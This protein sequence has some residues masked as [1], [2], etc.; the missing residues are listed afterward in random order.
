MSMHILRLAFAMVLCLFGCG[1]GDIELV[2]DIDAGPRDGVRHGYR[3]WMDDL[4]TSGSEKE[5]TLVTYNVANLGHG[6]DQ[7]DNVVK[8]IQGSGADLVGLNE[9]D[10]CNGRHD[11]NQ[12]KNLAGKL[13][14]WDFYFAKA[15]D[16]AGGSYGNGV[17]S[18]KPILNTT[19]VAIPQGSGHEPRSIALI[20]TEDVVFGAV[21]L[22]FGPPGEPSYEQA[23]F[24]NSWFSE[25]YMGYDK[26]VILCGDFNTDPGTPT[27]NEMERCWTRLSEPVLTWPTGTASMC[28]DY[29]FC[30]KGA[31]PVTTIETAR[32]T[33]I[34]DLDNASDHYPVRVKIKFDTTP[35]DIKPDR[36]VEK[37]SVDVSSVSLYGTA[38]DNAMAMLQ[39]VNTKGLAVDNLFEAYL[40][41]KGGNLVIIDD[42][43]T[44]WS[45]QEGGRIIPTYGYDTIAGADCATILL[46]LDFNNLSW[47]TIAIKGAELRPA[48]GVDMHVDLYY[49][50]NGQWQTR[51]S[52]IPSNGYSKY[53]FKVISDRPE[54]LY[55]WIRCADGS[56]GG[57]GEA[58]F[59]GDL[60][61]SATS[62]LLNTKVIVK[63]NLL[64][65][66]QLMHQDR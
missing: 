11:I 6:G 44:R 38:A 25:R 58:G 45:L 23:Q 34:I 3:R 29:I 62:S 40:P 41:P 15:L 7:T 1:C 64:D 33:G 50:G 32:P 51:E 43:G 5:L 14:E 65:R 30:F 42:A 36:G 10:S 37:G 47:E 2:P 22:D 13:G 56:V 63:V 20:E 66:T 19:T 17:L 55:A 16:F 59:S 31:L 52:F 46:R 4:P 54:A 26:P 18:A 28:L 49:K 48:A 12:M 57:V 24:I 39:A 8:F 61:F 60:A 21:H 53:Y 9:I 35:T 27:Q